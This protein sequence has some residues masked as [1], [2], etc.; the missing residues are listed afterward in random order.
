MVKMRPSSSLNSMRCFDRTS[1]A[2]NAATKMTVQM[3][4]APRRSPR[5]LRMLWRATSAATPSTIS[6]TTAM[7]DWTTRS[8]RV[9]GVSRISPG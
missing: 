9:R 8:Q 4:S 3:R 7:K 6:T 5:P 2:R 1:S